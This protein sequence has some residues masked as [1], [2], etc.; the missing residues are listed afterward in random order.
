MM[1]KTKLVDSGKRNTESTG[2]LLEPKDGHGRYDLIPPD[3]LYRLAKIYEEGAKKYADNNWKKGM[4]W[5]KCLNSLERHLQKWKMGMRDED[6]LAMVA[7]RAFALMYYEKHRKELCDIEERMVVEKVYDITWKINGNNVEREGW[8][9]D[10]MRG[11][12]STRSG[13]VEHKGEEEKNE[14]D[15]HSRKRRCRESVY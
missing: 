8:D 15:V 13:S 10:S 6:H 2:C 14:T 5:S 7:W 4:P 12:T 1:P 3:G 9:G 11:L